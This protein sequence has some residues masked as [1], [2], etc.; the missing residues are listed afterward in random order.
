MKISYILMCIVLLIIYYRLDKLRG[1][2]G[3]NGV[4]D[5]N[6][7]LNFYAIKENNEIKT[8]EIDIDDITLEGG[9]N[10]RDKL[11]VALVSLE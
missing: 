4:F 6:K 5:T 3:A 2:Q 9:Y 10:Y 8:Y 7:F 11:T 1:C